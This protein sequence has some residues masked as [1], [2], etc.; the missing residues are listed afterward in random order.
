MTTSE[1]GAGHRILGSL[2]SAD[3]RGVVRMQDR[4]DSDI[5]DV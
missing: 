5:D 4:F 1:A 2:R 3:G